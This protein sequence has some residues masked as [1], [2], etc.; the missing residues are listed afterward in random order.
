MVERFDL[1]TS[2]YGAPWADALGGVLAVTSRSGDNHLRVDADVF[3]E[4]RD[5]VTTVNA[6][7]AASLPIVK[8]RLFVV[9]SAWAEEA[10]TPAVP[11]PDRP[12]ANHPGPRSTTLGAALKLTW[13]LRPGQR[14]ESLTLL[15]STRRDYT[16]ALNVTEDAQPT[17]AEDNV[18]T[19][20]RFV[21]RLNDIFSV[22]EQMAFQSFRAEEA[23]LLCRTNPGT[24][25]SFAGAMNTFPS[26]VTAGNWPEHH[27]E[28]DTEWQMAAG[29][30][31]RLK[32]SPRVSER[33]RFNSRTR[34]QHLGWRSHTPGDRV[35][36]LELG[37]RAE[38][39]TF[40]NDAQFEPPLLGWFSTA[41][42]WWTSFHAFESETR[43][44]ERLWIVPGMGMS[45]S[46]VRAD[47]FSLHAAAT[48]PHLGLA[49]NPFADGRTW[50]RASIHQRAAGDLQELAEL[51]RPTATTRRCQWDDGTRSFSSN[52]SWSGGPGRITVGLPCGPANVS[53][54]GTPCNEGLRLASGWEYALGGTQELGRGFRGG[55]DLVY[56]KPRDLPATLETNQIWGATGTNVV[57]FNTGRAGRVNDDSPNAASPARYLGATAWL[58]KEAG[59]LR[60]LAS[61]TLSRHEGVVDSGGVISQTADGLAVEDRAQVFRTLASYDVKGYAS[62]GL[63]YSFETGTPAYYL[64]LYGAT[65]R[66]TSV[67]N[68][69]SAIN[70]PGDPGRPTR[71]ASRQRLNLQGRFRARR[72]LGVDLDLYVDLVDLLESRQT[73]TAPDSFITVATGEGRRIRAGL[74][75]RY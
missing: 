31:A 11:E 51:L 49:F 35:T 1:A 39:V 56:R 8:D 22:R 64:P 18:A 60:L 74:Q 3:S 26:P 30:E 27:I 28:R 61:Y 23:P 10:R 47:D 43:L 38:T 67:G 59:A 62:L 24:C 6:M 20:L 55:M 42:S 44:Y 46:Q 14:I 21:A 63:L 57:G 53:A 41:S 17:F 12:I 16:G 2:G 33:L 15:D 13:L 69:G 19:S 73:A 58:Q 65:G 4:P 40:A 29:I 32:E 5:S 45:F 48:T 9:A 68:P 70:D 54:D 36:A 75:Y 66:F 37:P 25:D 50:L 34:L 72:F 52:C 71:T 7:T